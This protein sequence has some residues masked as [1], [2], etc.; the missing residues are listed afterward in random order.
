MGL[1]CLDLQKYYYAALLSHSHNWFASDDSNAS[2][3]LEAAF[4]DSY[5][6]LKNALYRGLQ[7]PFPLTLSMKAV[8]RAW[9]MQVCKRHED[10]NRWSPAT[11][12]WNNSC[13]PEFQTI[14]DSVI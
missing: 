3:V 12:L 2:V 10:P 14:P 6:S 7:G 5:E 1:A 9:R 4:L 8:I 13:L 11:S